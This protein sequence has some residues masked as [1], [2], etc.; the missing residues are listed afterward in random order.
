MLQNLVLKK[1]LMVKD[2]I[3]H[4]LASNSNWNYI[5]FGLKKNCKILV[6]IHNI[7]VL[8]NQQKFDEI[9]MIMEDS[10]SVAHKKTFNRMEQYLGSEVLVQILVIICHVNYF[11]R[12]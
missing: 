1:D 11:G 3:L 10:F 2:L 9:S 7:Y 5:V 8:R 4:G 6:V 12:N